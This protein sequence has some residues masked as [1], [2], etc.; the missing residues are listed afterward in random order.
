[1]F[2]EE[3]RALHGHTVLEPTRES[4][5]VKNHESSPD[6]DDEVEDEPESELAEDEE[7]DEESEDVV[8][9]ESDDELDED[10]GLRLSLPE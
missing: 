4:L 7:L 1:M 5:A 2:V 3:R 10:P 9:E 8:L 6:D